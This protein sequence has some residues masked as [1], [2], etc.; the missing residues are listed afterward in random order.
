MESGVLHYLECT[1]PILVL[2]GV[3]KWNHRRMDRKSFV[4]FSVA[5]CDFI[6]I[7]LLEVAFRPC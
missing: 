6:I 5:F 1:A 4:E 7:M 2:H 3:G